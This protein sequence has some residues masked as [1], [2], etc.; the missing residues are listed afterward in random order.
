[1]TALLA[2]PRFA[3]A[4]ASLATIEL[5]P[6]RHTAADAHAHSELVAQT[7][8]RLARQ[9]GCDP[10][11]VALLE[12]LGRAHDI[13]KLTGTAK[14]ERSLALLEEW[15]ASSDDHLDPRLLELVKWHDTNL[16]WWT[17]TQRGQPPSDKAWRRLASKV[18]LRLL[19][20]F[21]VADRVD[22]PGGWRRNAPALWFI[23]QARAR[24][25]VEE[26]R[27]DLPDIPSEVCAGAALVHDGRV[28]VIRVRASGWEL[29]KGG[30]EFDELPHEAA[31]RELREEAGVEGHF[32]VE[33]EL[34]STSHAVAGH[35]K[36]VHYFRVGVRGDVTLGLRPN[37]TRERQWV[38]FD[39]LG[40]LPLV[41]ESL[42]G[43]L[44]E[45]VRE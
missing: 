29:P 7:A 45:T 3:E 31:L 28:L 6:R 42:R 18:D 23:E 26:L 38:R 12:D 30:L 35:Q 4:Y 10:A 20:L 19:C 5:N 34:A 9:N 14:P 41:A 25:Y 11:D 43:V 15:F 44:N 33:R 37:R 21:M 27:L 32:E 8:G 24:G 16:P 1:M 36:R 17:S 39:E 22:A 40:A 2:N 13:G